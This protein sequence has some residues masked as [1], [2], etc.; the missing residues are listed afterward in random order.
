[1]EQSPVTAGAH[2]APVAPEGRIDPLLTLSADIFEN[3]VQATLPVYDGYIRE[4]L[5]PVIADAQ[6]QVHEARDQ[7]IFSIYDI[8]KEHKEEFKEKFDEKF[9]S[10]A[11][12]HEETLD[13]IGAKIVS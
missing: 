6:S 8:L 5:M 9:D 1:M 12:E 4:Q 10:Y 2:F 13:A 7:V 11:K 3:N